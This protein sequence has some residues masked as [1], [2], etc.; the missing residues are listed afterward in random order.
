AVQ[1]FLQAFPEDG[2]M[3]LVLVSRLRR[4]DPR[5]R[6]LLDQ[7]AVKRRVIVLDGVDF[8]TLRALYQKARI[9]FFPSYVEGFGLPLLEAM[10]SDTPAVAANRSAPLEVAGDAALLCS[11]FSVD[12]MADALRTLDGDETLRAQLVEKGR[13]RVEHFTFAR[14]AAITL[15]AYRRVVASKGKGA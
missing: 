4:P 9:F 11:P 1:A 8:Q 10:A 6:A 14:A 7:P 15:D 2:P 13:A 3:R 12:A 5:L